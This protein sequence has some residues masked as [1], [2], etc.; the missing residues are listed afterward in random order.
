MG[1]A[2]AKD[3][4]H[5]GRS[6]LAVHVDPS[7]A[8][9]VREVE[10]RFIVKRPRFSAVEAIE[11]RGHVGIGCFDGIQSDGQRVVVRLTNVALTFV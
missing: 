6:C 10:V 7:G 5:C 11:V 2:L 8:V 4:L 1:L 3:Q 9:P